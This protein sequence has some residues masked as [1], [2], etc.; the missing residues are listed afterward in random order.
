MNTMHDKL[1]Q[2]DS[3]VGGVVAE[4]LFDDAERVES[5][6]PHSLGNQVVWSSV[7]SPGP[8]GLTLTIALA[9]HDMAELL[10]SLG[11]DDSEAT[12]SDLVAELANTLCG[13]LVAELQGGG[14]V[15]LDLPVGGTGV[16]WT[17]A[18]PGTTC[19]YETSEVRFLISL[20]PGQPGRVMG[21]SPQLPVPN[22]YQQK[23]S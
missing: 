19:V 18:V 23:A 2:L 7:A 21:S 22:L 10:E 11:M 1:E 12:R 13:V 5:L 6:D 8:D 16:E 15:D 17:D 4:M 20:E 9:E 14:A 3:V